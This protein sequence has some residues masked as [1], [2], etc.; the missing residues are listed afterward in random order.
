MRLQRSTILYA[1]F[2]FNAAA[3]A[4]PAETDRGLAI[5]QLIQVVHSVQLWRDK[6]SDMFPSKA[7]K[8]QGLFDESV[9]KRYESLFESANSFRNPSLSRE[10]LLRSAGQTVGEAQEW[11]DVKF[12]AVIQSMDEKLSVEFEVN[13]ALF[14]EELK[15][16]EGLEKNNK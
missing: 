3:L 15:K 14:Y 2:S 10:Q 6:C 13:K 4:D 12:S 7:H 1:I 5:G 16:Y 9:L 11:C 8:Y